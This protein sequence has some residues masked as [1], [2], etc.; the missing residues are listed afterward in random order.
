MY[1]NPVQQQH[2]AGVDIRVRE[3]QRTLFFAKPRHL[4]HYGASRRLPPYRN[5]PRTQRG[6][7]Q[8]SRCRVHPVRLPGRRP[9]SSLREISAVCPW[10]PARIKTLVSGV[11]SS[12]AQPPPPNS[13]LQTP[14]PGS[15]VASYFRTSCI[16]TRAT[17]SLC[18]SACDRTA[19]RTVFAHQ[20]EP[21]SGAPSTRLPSVICSLTLVSCPS[22]PPNRSLYLLT[23]A[24]SDIPALTGS[25]RT[26][27][28]RAAGSTRRATVSSNSALTSALVDVSPCSSMLTPQVPSLYK[29]L[30]LC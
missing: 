5:S 10:E 6:T 1:G 22:A 2:I 8:S 11:N 18:K 7:V 17:V 4:I 3:R 12:P 9:G 23:S 30:S 28:I 19:H 14:P 24:P 27:S 16:Q 13:V 26:P 21:A 25:S 29:L 20:G 15:W